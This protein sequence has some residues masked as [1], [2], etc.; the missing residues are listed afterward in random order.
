LLETIEQELGGR[1]IHKLEVFT[2][3]ATVDYEPYDLTRRFY[4]AMGFSEVSVEPKGFSSGDDKLLLR[5]QLDH[6]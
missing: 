1:G 5:R 4:Y 6:K 2:L 3:A